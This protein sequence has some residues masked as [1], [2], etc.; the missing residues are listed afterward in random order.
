MK[1]PVYC[2]FIFLLLSLS[3]FA[4]SPVLL[5]KSGDKGLHIDHSVAS[6]ESF[7]SIGRFYHVHP[8]FLASYNG[9]DMNKGLSIGQ[10]LNIPLTDTNFSQKTKKGIPIYYVVGEKEGLLKVSNANNKVS[11][12]SLRE[13]NKLPNDDLAV[14]SKLIV[15]YVNTTG[16]VALASNIPKEE[17][18]TAV[19]EKPIVK[20]EPVAEKPIVKEEVK[21]QDPPEQKA[22][23]KE[24]PKKAPPQARPSET[25]NMSGQGYFKT[26]FDQQVKQT[27]V[28]KTETVTSG[29][30]RTSN[31]VQD[32]K[33]YL[34]KD[35]IPSG[36]V[37]RIINPENNKAVYA[38]VLGEM[39]GIRQNQGLN[40]RISNIA[41]TTLGISEVDKFIVKISY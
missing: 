28:S 26:T 23:V 30:F 20:T 10:T 40:I 17:P 27:P 12:Q 8:K 15:G 2:L 22:I 3:S 38:K 16:P 9:L 32:A 41:A 11:L 25:S 33:Y 34:L 13:W 18:K 14:G 37:V 19:V 5:V 7:F 21:K 6:K 1:N 29:I 36:T 4:Q 35:G 24:V 31:G 39:S